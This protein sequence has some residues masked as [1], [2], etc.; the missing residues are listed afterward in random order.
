MICRRF[1][2]S[3]FF[4]DNLTNIHVI[5]CTSLFLGL[6]CGCV[7]QMDVSLPKSLMHS[8]PLRPR[9]TPHYRNFKDFTILPGFR[10]VEF[11]I[12]NPVTRMIRES[13]DT[14]T[15]I[16]SDYG[17]CLHLLRIFNFHTFLLL[18]LHSSLKYYILHSYKILTNCYFS[19]LYLWCYRI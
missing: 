5:L 6:P 9:Q 10:S 2:S 4:S 11:F 14:R 3:P 15:L 8:L 1:H 16:N 12:F 18:R 13:E 19:Y 17:C 7:F